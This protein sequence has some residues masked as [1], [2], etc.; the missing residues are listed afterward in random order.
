M[1]A[2]Q[3]LGAAK[4]RAEE[5]WRPD[6]R[7]VRARVAEGL[8]LPPVPTRPRRLGPPRA[9]TVWAV[10]MVKNEADIIARTLHHLLEQEVDGILVADNGST[11]GTRAIVED[12]ASSAPIFLADDREPAFFQGPK[13]TRLSHWAR[14]AGAAWVIPFDADELWFARS[15]TVGAYLRQSR[16]TVV[17]ASIFNVAPVDAAVRLGD[18]A[19]WVMG[20]QASWWK[21]V[22]FRP[23]PFMAVAMGNHEVDRP[24]LPVDGL[25]IAHLP[26][27]SLDQMAGKLRAGAASLSSIPGSSGLHWRDLGSLSDEELGEV[28]SQL[29]AGGAGERVQWLPEGELEPVDVFSWT[30]WGSDV[31]LV[32]EES[33]TV[34]SEPRGA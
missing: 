19:G 18:A 23:H 12:L 10:T 2:R 34:A 27:R 31:P 26:Y 32:P 14:R 24:G 3:Q 7:A 9:D 30:S 13:M 1:S 17:R 15:Q 11:D 28:W 22:A 4:R 8:T 33:A 25:G 16:A 21:K 5:W 29:L 6:E 20:R